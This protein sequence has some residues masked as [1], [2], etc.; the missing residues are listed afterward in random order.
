M[1]SFICQAIEW[2]YNELPPSSPYK[3]YLVV[4]APWDNNLKGNIHP[5]LGIADYY[6]G[7]APDRIYAREPWHFSITYSAM[8]KEILCWADVGNHTD[9][10]RKFLEK[11]S[12]EKDEII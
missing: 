5:R 3:K 9:I 2:H 11:I 12:E 1:S 6:T 8:E 10:V 7:N 4:Y